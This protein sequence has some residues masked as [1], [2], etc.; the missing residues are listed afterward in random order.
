M[1]DKVATTIS[2]EDDNIVNHTEEVVMDQSKVQLF[3]LK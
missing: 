3:Q 1:I 2:Q